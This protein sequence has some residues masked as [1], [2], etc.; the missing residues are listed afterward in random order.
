[1]VVGNGGEGKAVAPPGPCRAAL[2]CSLG[3]RCALSPSV[4][5]RDAFTEN[6]LPN[7][8]PTPDGGREIRR[9]SA[10]ARHL[11]P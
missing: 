3:M 4:V 7:S 6:L 8:T 11:F 2:V 1:M 5:P 9:G 10:G